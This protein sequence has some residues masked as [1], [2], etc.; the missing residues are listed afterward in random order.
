MKII[1]GK[2]LNCS[3]CDKKFAQNGELKIHERSHTGERP[4]VCTICGN[5][6]KTSSMRA[7]HMDAHIQ[8]KTFEVII[9]IC[10]SKF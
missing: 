9:Y 10:L 1:K 3:Y 8:G 4:F 6:Y 5:A 2:T 7:A